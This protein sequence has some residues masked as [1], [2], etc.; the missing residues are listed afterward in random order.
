MKQFID[1][2]QAG[3][4]LANRLTQY[5]KIA[6]V[7]VLGLP[8]GG[9]PVAYEIAKKL[10]V[11]LD[12]FIVRKLGVPGHEELAMGALASGDVTIF[13]QDILNTI[14]AKKAEIDKV[15][16]DEQV[17]LS[18]RQQLYRGHR[19]KSVF[20]NKTIILVDD[21]I[22]TGASIRAAVMALKRIKVKK[23][24]IAVPVAAKDTAKELRSIVDD[25][26]CLLKPV[27]LLAVGHWYQN[28][29]QTSDEE[30]INLLHR[31]G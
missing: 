14:Q 13:N 21:G 16:R 15:I 27:D 5:S 25:L 17:E 24:I 6:N 31:A 20:T 3:Q 10:L 9:V 2:R 1:R 18:R 26:V 28:F 8:R 29:S 11:P 12:V 19:P 4:Q 23:I 7:V 30:V 22:A